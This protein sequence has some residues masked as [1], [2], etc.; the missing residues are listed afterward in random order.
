MVCLFQ[1]FR[2]VISRFFIVIFVFVV[3][4][5]RISVFVVF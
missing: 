2:D 4:S 5:V 1:C 3:E